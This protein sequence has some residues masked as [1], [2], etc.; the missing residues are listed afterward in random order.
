MTVIIDYT[1]LE[2]S[3]SVRVVTGAEV[4]VENRAVGTVEGVHSAIAVAEVIRLEQKI[5]DKI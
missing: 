2:V 3:Y 5:R 1:L 4:L